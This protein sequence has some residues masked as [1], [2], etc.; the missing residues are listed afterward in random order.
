MSG[1]R[2]LIGNSLSMLS[3]RLVQGVATFVLTAAIARLLGAEALGQYLLAFSYYFIFVGAISDGPKTLFTRE[4]ARA[5]E[6]TPVFLVNGTLLQFLLSLVGYVGLVTVVFMLPYSDSTS[7][8][9]YIMGLT[10]FPF[11]LSNVTEAIL[12]AQERMHLIAIA[13]VPVYIVRLVLIIKLMMLGYGVTIIAGVIGLSELLILLIE[14]LMILP[15]LKLRWIIRPRFIWHTFLAS[16]TFIGMGAMAIFGNRMQLLILSLLGGEQLVGVYGGI[17]QLLQPFL[18][19]ANSLV[20]ATF[21]R[22]SQAIELGKTSQRQIVEKVIELLLCISLPFLVGL[23]F[24]GEDLLKFIYSDS[25]FSEATMTLRIAS[26]ALIFLPF[27]RVTSFL[28]VANGFEKLNLVEIIVTN[29]IGGV[30]G[31]LLISN[32]H[33][34]GAA[35]ADLVISVSGFGQY[36]FITHRRLFPLRFLRIVRY[37]LLISIMMAAVFTVLQQMH[38]DF[39]LMLI[40]STLL[41]CVLIAVFSAYTLGGVDVLRAKLSKRR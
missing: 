15:K 20:L 5:P 40:M 8:A 22:M 4:L 26:L 21:P 37:P 7:T 14:W 13:T 24:V 32:Y 39:L 25:S 27:I 34:L 11:S 9:C 6:E 30:M 33:L 28:L 12:Q 29:V 10:I 19:I 35:M 3:N 41:Y 31:V 38:L 36:I 1:R 23:Y 17:A 2:K 18:I 16:R